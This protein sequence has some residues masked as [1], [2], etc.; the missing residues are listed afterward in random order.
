MSKFKAVKKTDNKEENTE[1]AQNKLRILL[2]TFGWPMGTV[3]YDYRSISKQDLVGVLVD[4]ILS[5]I[6]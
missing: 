2:C 6:I 1:T 4:S 5:L 3:L